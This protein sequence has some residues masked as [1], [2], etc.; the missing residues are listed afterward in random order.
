MGVLKRNSSVQRPETDAT[1]SLDTFPSPDR[2]NTASGAPEHNKFQPNH[3]GFHSACTT[4]IAPIPLKIGR[5]VLKERTDKVQTCGG[6]YIHIISYMSLHFVQNTLLRHCSTRAKKLVFRKKVDQKLK[7]YFSFLFCWK[8][9]AK[10]VILS[11]C[12][13]ESVHGARRTKQK[14]VRNVKYSFI[15][16]F[17]EGTAPCSRIPSLKTSFASFS[18]FREPILTNSSSK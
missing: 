10:P 18:E 7:I 2:P 15:A 3:F 14:K 6:A 4:F 12:S 5:K 13:P 11:Y 8:E 17:K 16:K 9:L 1:R